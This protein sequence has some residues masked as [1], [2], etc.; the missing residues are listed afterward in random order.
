MLT[1][2]ILKIINTI[3]HRHNSE[4]EIKLYKKIIFVV[5]ST[6]LNLNKNFKIILD[7]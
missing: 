4:I 7:A 5:D 1:K 3:K 2:L 6:M